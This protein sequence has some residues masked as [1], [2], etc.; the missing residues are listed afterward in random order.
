MIVE[1]GTPMYGGQCFGNYHMSIL[2]LVSELSKRG[3]GV[4]FSHTYNESLIQRARNTIAT[5]FLIN[6][7]ADVLLFIDSDISFNAV[8][9]VDMLEE[10]RDVIGAVTPLKSINFK[11]I[12]Q[13][14]IHSRSLDDLNKL[15]GYFNINTINGEDI[16]EDVLNGKSFEVQ[17]IGTGVMSI[18]R[19][20]LESLSLKVKSY[21]DD[22]PIETIKDRYDFFPVTI[23]LDE[24]FGGNRMMS[25]DYNFC[26]LWK[27]EG[28][29]IYAKTGVVTGHNG[30]YE[31]S[32]DLEKSIMLKKIVNK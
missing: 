17:R 10:E 23:E 6:K 12:V 29:K 18:K 22:N 1:I 7:R 31:Y 15:G 3:H 16:D 20:V 8:K 26:N 4:L 30:F 32:G 13:G 25:E 2:S 24:V 19:N 14:A 5:R 21:L 11:S 27:N 9:M 28:G